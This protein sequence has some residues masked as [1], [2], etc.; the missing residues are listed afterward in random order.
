VNGEKIDP[1]DFG[2][3]A[4]FATLTLMKKTQETIP[5]KEIVEAF[6]SA[7]GS[8]EVSKALAEQFEDWTV[9]CLARGSI[10]LAAIWTA[11]WTEGNGGQTI[12]D[13]G[14]VKSEDLISLYSDRSEL[15]SMHLDTIEPELQMPAVIGP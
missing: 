4:G 6:K 13:G 5:P 2:Q 10:Y 11:A 3:A 12:G 14:L 7:S 9:T 1:I 8:Q 15:P